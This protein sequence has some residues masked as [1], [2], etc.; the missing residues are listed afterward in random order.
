MINKLWMSGSHVLAVGYREWLDLKMWPDLLE[1]RP[2]VSG[3]WGRGIWTLQASR[4][5]AAACAV[6]PF[7]TLA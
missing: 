3:D 4:L 2:A 6:C 5:E 1:V 7:P